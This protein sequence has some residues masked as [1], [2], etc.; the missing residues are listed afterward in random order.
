[1][2]PFEYII[3][4]VTVIA[5]LGIADLLISFNKLLVARHRIQWDWLPLGAATLAVLAIFNF[6]WGFYSF[7]EVVSTITLGRFAPFGI[8]LIVLFLL[9]AGALPDEVP[10]EGLDLAKFYDSNGK[11]FWLL[12]ATYI[13]IN[14]V[15][16]GTYL[17]TLDST[18][19]GFL[20]ILSAQL[21]NLITL[22]FF[23]LLAFVR[24]RWLHRIV[25]V[26]MIIFYLFV[27]WDMK[28]VPA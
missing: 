22:A 2:T 25:I 10:E 4:I 6:W 24:N 27:W 16:R 17:L 20:D 5:G 26:I 23:L 8:G 14:I 15:R 1:M 7:Q 9:N 28:L 13:V 12:Y 18:E 11:Y 19:I 3:P 21:L